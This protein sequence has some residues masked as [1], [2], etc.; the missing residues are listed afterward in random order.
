LWK[1]ETFRAALLFEPFLPGAVGGNLVIRFLSKIGQA[2]GA[3]L[4][5]CSDALWL[6]GQFISFSL[7]HAL[8]IPHS[9][10]SSTA[11]IFPVLKEAV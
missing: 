9:L 3:A 5:K 8:C 7:S 2:W 6:S 4:H 1:R 10:S 11:G